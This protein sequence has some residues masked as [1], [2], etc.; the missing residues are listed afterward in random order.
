MVLL[1]ECAS[2]CCIACRVCRD[3]ARGY[4]L[5]AQ[6][7]AE[8]RW[9][10]GA[11]RNALGLNLALASDMPIVAHIYGM[12][13]TKGR[14][15]VRFLAHEAIEAPRAYA[16]GCRCAMPMMHALSV[17]RLPR[18]TSLRVLIALRQR[19]SGCWLHYWWHCWRGRPG[20]SPVAA[21]ELELERFARLQAVLSVDNQQ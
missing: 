12:R 21:E 5:H 13:S 1:V 2:A 15:G 18:L 3:A 16:R 14:S 10:G 17:T 8:R 19:L 11:P 6:A 7:T 20:G 4:S 9:L